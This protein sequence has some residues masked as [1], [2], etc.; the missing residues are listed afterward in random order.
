MTAL[1]LRPGVKNPRYWFP[2]RID[3]AA[4]KQ[5]REKMLFRDR[6]TCQF[7]GHRADKF[8]QAHHVERGDDNKLS[9]LVTCCVACHAV[10]HFGR[11]LAL[12]AIEIWQSPLSQVEIVQR[13]RDGIGL[14]KTL[15]Q[16]KRTLKL[17][18]GPLAPDAIEYA[19]SIIKR[20]SK[21]HTF[22]LE[23]PLRVVFVNFKRWQ[24]DE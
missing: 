21:E 16:I 9:N 22:Y 8:M 19:N 7:C 10:N 1:A 18:R 17:K 4:W 12:G 14:G 11:N 6:F 23:D 5:L 24:I 13:T 15:A 2:D 3:Q 20:R